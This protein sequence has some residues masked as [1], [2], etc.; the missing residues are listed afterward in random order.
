MVGELRIALEYA[1]KTLAQDSNAITNYYRILSTLPRL[2]P[3]TLGTSREQ[4]SLQQNYIMIMETRSN[5]RDD[6][7]IVRRTYRQQSQ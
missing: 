3:T 7:R 2:V 1:L 5:L 6:T 4:R